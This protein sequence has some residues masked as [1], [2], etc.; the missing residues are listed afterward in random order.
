[1]SFPL[2]W[3]GCNRDFHHVF[4][5]TAPADPPIHAAAQLVVLCQRIPI[6]QYGLDALLRNDARHGL[7]DYLESPDL[8]KMYFQ[9]IC[10]GGV[11]CASLAIV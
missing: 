10:H 2:D 11:G 4:L 7:A 1:M 3:R 5:K 8:N 6:N 9:N